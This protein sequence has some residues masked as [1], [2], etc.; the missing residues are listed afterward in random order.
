MKED[1][2]AAEEEDQD[3]RH[4]AVPRRVGL[5]GG[6]EW[7]NVSVEALGVPAGSEADVG[8]LRRPVV[9]DTF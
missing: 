5:E 1:G 3:D 6:F 7:E 9:N 2:E 8:L 4:E